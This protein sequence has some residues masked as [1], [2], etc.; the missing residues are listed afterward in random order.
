MSGTRPR[1]DAAR[2]VADLETLARFG[3]TERGG[4]ARVAYSPADLEARDWLDAQLT[5]LGLEVRRDPVGTT[6]AVLAG[7][8]PGLAPI[9]VGSHTDTVPEGGRYDGALGVVAALACARAIAAGGPSLRHPLAVVDFEAE[10]ATMGGA[11]LASRAMTGA[12]DEAA[13]ARPAYDGA[14]A[15]EHL[16]RAGLD[17]AKVAAAALRRG[18]FAAFLELHIEQGATLEADGVPIAVVQGIVGIRRFE[19]AFTGSA[20]HAGTTPMQDRDDALVAA[21]PFVVAVRD[22]AIEQ[23]LVGTVGTLRVHPGAPSVVPGR[24][25]MDVELRSTDE[26]RLDAAEEQLAR[27]AAG[28]GG[29]AVR[30]SAKAPAPFAP[31]LLAMLEDVCRASGLEH[32]RMWSGAGHDAGVLTAITDAAMLFVPSRAGISHNAAEFTEPRDCVRGARALLD[33]IVAVDGAR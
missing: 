20:A 3:A 12:L 1:I 29:E 30:L 31:P 11:T 28:M 26:T 7:T 8:E 15:A 14:P 27:R 25:V 18:A 21:A 16:R 33:W 5:G 9:A 13:L 19:V 24:V 23:G 17:P 2:L 32:R 4:V 10:E 22:I 6:I